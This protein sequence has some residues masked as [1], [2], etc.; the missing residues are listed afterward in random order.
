MQNSAQGTSSLAILHEPDGIWA[1]ASFAPL[2]AVTFDRITARGGAPRQFISVSEQKQGRRFYISGRVQ[3]VGYRLFAS[4]AAQRQGV[5]GYV[6]NLRDGRVEVY[7]IGTEAQLSALMMELR[8]GPRLAS[9][10]QVSEADAELL[11]EFA[12]RFS[13]D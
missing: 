1:N 3:G 11:L 13:I 8:S 2:W 9:V 5:T 12:S 6:R 4:D 10:E 7:A